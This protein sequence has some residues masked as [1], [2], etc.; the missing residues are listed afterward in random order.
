MS[1]VRVHDGWPDVAMQNR[2][3]VGSIS[4]IVFCA[5]G[6]LCSMSLA[7]NSVCT[8]KRTPSPD[9]LPLFVVTEITPYPARDPYSDAAA[10]PF[11]TSMLSMSFGLMSASEADAI[12]STPS[13]MNIGDCDRPVAS[14]DCGPRS[15]IEGTAPGRPEVDTMFAPVTLPCSSASGLEFGTGMSA[16]LTCATT[17]G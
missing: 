3:C 8:L 2:F 6:I 17:N 7:P 14:I 10:A 12:C 4:I 9:A 1:T 13:T 15:T 16:E 5:T 11:T